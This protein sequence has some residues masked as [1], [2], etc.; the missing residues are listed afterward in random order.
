[1]LVRSKSAPSGRELDRA[2]GASLASPVRASADYGAGS[3]WRPPRDGRRA[4]H[5]DSRQPRTPL[6]WTAAE[7]FGVSRRERRTGRNRRRT[8][9]DS[10][11]EQRHCPDAPL[12]GQ[13][14]QGRA[15][16]PSPGLGYSC[17]SPLTKGRGRPGGRRTTP[18]RLLRCGGLPLA[19]TRVRIEGNWAGLPDSFNRGVDAAAPPT[20]PTATRCTSSRTTSTSATTSTAPTA[21]TLCPSRATGTSSA[22]PGPS[23]STGS[24]IVMDAI[25]SHTVRPD[26]EQVR[27]GYADDA[28]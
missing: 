3:A 13:N 8:A 21:A 25:T 1:M 27:L 19:A 23:L 10:Y 11:A 24:V 7:D 22:D 18:V 26:S 16:F 12:R 20:P 17:H 2:C 5:D 6:L 14:T 15:G 4:D 28:S 9:D